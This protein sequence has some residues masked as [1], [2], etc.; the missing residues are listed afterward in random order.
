MMADLSSPIY[1][2][3]DENDPQ[4]RL[5]YL[6]PCDGGDQVVTCRMTTASLSEDLQYHALSYVWGDPRPTDDI[7]LNGRPFRIAKNLAAALEYLRATTLVA[8]ET[9][10]PIWIDAIC[11]NQADLAERSQQVAIMGSIYGGARCVLSWLG[12]PNRSRNYIRDSFLENEEDL[13]MAHGFALIRAVSA[14]IDSRR[15][16]GERGWNDNT[17][18]TAQDFEWIAQNP[19][20]YKSDSKV[21]TGNQRWNTIVNINYATYWTRIW[22][23]QEMVFAS[24]PHQHLIFCGTDY[25]TYHQLNDLHE[26]LEKVSGQRPPRPSFMSLALWSLMTERSSM[27]FNMMNVINYLRGIV[28]GSSARIVPYI[29]QQCTCT[30]PRD[31]IYGLLG[32]FANS[33]VPDYSKPVPEVYQDWFADSL[34]RNR[35]KNIMTWSGIGHDFANRHDIPSWI[36]VL[37]ELS[38]EAV[39]SGII[40]D[41]YDHEVDPWLDTV[42]LETPRIMGDGLLSIHG[43][44]LDTVSEVYYP[45]EHEDPSNQERLLG[46]CIDFAT[47]Y[48]GRRYKTGLPPFNAVLAVLL[49]GH[50]S[51]KNQKLTLPLEPSNLL[52]LAFRAILMPAYTDTSQEAEHLKRT[53]DSN[54]FDVEDEET[55][56]SWI[57]AYDSA[58]DSQEIFYGVR[59]LLK[60]IVVFQKNAFFLTPHGYL[61]MGPPQTNAGDRICLLQGSTLPSLVRKVASHWAYVGTCYVEGLSR[62][63]PLQMINAEEV[64]VEELILV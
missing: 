5:L 27:E 29:S 42:Q 31:T 56:R 2:A 40:Q 39:S 20:F 21:I 54:L 43:V 44:R 16:A 17:V 49:E 48:N 22:T 11:I 34:R 35:F 57:E 58:V 51:F 64:Q 26:F 55:K 30:D 3:L 8:D 53:I 13:P 52:A 14:Y 1:W 60:R 19:E 23:V 63:E 4:I 24:S 36:P 41:Y 47:K 25:V 50:D 46:F 59:A 9:A 12:E 28:S 7:I 15:E 62:G 38:R 33:V 45:L 32:V 61:G 10:L 18:L 6:D 37:H